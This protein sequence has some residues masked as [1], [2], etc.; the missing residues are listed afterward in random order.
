MTNTTIATLQHIALLHRHQ[1]LM[2]DMDARMAVAK[3]I[4]ALQSQCAPYTFKGMYT[5]YKELTI[6]Q[7]INYKSYKAATEHRLLWA[8]TDPIVWGY[9]STVPC[10]P[11]AGQPLFIH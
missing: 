10:F 3:Q 8:V 4:T 7:R 11:D 5:A 1:K 6:D 9:L 2:P